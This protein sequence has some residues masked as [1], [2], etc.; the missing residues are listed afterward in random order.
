MTIE[1]TDKLNFSP[2][3]KPGQHIEG[4]L[5]TFRGF[6]YFLSL[7]EDGPPKSLDGL[8]IGEEDL[9]ACQL[10]FHNREI[11]DMEKGYLSQIMT[12]TW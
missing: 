12:I 8:S 5:F 1:S 3:I 6:Y 7:E 11:K 2:V 10:N 9:G 4:G